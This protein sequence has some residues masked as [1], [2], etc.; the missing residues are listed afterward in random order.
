MTTAG[1][2]FGPGPIGA[3]DS[4]RVSSPRV[5]RLAEDDWRMWY[6]GRDPS[7][8]RQI[9]LPT[10]RCGL[11]TSKD[12]LVWTRYSGPLT[13]GSVFEPSAIKERFDSGHVGV[14]DVRRDDNLFWMWYFGG[15]QNV[16][17]VG[18]QTT[19]GL[20]MRPGCAVSGNG[21]DWVRIEGRYAG[22]LMDVGAAGSF[23]QLFC[24]WPTVLREDDGTWKMYYHSLSPLT[25]FSIGVATSYDR[26]TWTK[27]GAVL[28]PGPSGSFDER[29]A[30][31]RHVHK[32]NGRYEMYYEGLGAD[33]YR[34]I[35]LA[36]STDG[37]TWTRVKGRAKNGAVFLH[38]PKGSG[39]WDAYAVGCPCVVELSNGQM[40]MYYIGSNEVAGGGGELALT[41]QIGL[42][43]SED[44]D[45]TSWTRWN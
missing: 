17:S 32:R 45:P 39:R 1:L 26:L 40:R 2:I 8:D 11:A 33:G 43:V 4:E 14:S 36:T 27:I 35:G 28:G 38:A 12:G 41:H 29:G 42:C 44:G 25:G 21:V 23:D 9:N 15:A 3:W 7:F 10:G 22:A 13:M 20:P 37:L 19:K 6:Y 5:L 30:A 18:S 31:T 34:S 24:G 16:I